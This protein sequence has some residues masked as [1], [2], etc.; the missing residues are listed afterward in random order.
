M[1]ENKKTNKYPDLSEINKR[2]SSL[3]DINLLV[4]LDIIH[5][6]DNHESIEN[7]IIEVE[8]HLKVLEEM[9]LC[10]KIGSKINKK[11]IATSLSAKNI[12]KIID[13]VPDVSQEEIS[14]LKKQIEE[15]NRQINSL[16][17][18]KTA[19]KTGKKEDIND[20]KKRLIAC[21]KTISCLNGQISKLN[22]LNIQL[23][24]I[25][26]TNEEKDIMKKQISNMN[27]KFDNL[28]TFVIENIK[29]KV[30]EDRETLQDNMPIINKKNNL[31]TMKINSLEKTIKNMAD[32]I[33]ELKKEKEEKYIKEKETFM[34]KEKTSPVEYDLIERE[35][36]PGVKEGNTK[37]RAGDELIIPKPIS[38]KILPKES[39]SEK[40]IEI[41][42]K[43]DTISEFMEKANKILNATS[44]KKEEYPQKKEQINN[45]SEIIKKDKLLDEIEDIENE[46]EEKKKDK[47]Q[48]E[49]IK[50]EIKD[51]EIKEDAYD[52]D[53]NELLKEIEKFEKK[54]L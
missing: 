28:K 47:N 32:S 4:K 45:K 34:N 12:K 33:I 42:P 29:N 23:R 53:E 9:M 36:N 52:S 3:E 46:F 7:R 41:K 49:E 5:I 1:K 40:N 35:V 38:K 43:N 31:N 25:K 37:Y 18:T 6:Q 15:T 13:E 54:A 11:K 21:E 8:E 22:R 44:N 48:N 2:I 24:D 16:R 50:T 10:T 30:H 19:H 39:L 17:D 27:D 51:K 26:N 20:L 14:S